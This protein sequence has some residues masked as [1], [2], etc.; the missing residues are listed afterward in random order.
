MR[1]FPMLTSLGR[2]VVSVPS[3]R[4]QLIDAYAVPVYNFPIRHFIKEICH[5]SYGN[6]LHKVQESTC[7]LCRNPSISIKQAG[8]KV[9]HKFHHLKCA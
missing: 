6:K 1:T 5:H 7:T 3:T 4:P 9:Q 8:V 2:G